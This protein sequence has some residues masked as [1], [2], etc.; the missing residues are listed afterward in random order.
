MGN[1]STSNFEQVTIGPEVV[2]IPANF[3]TESQITEITIP[4]TVTYIG[5]GSFSGCTSLE[6]LTIPSS[7]TTIKYAAFQGC[8]ITSLV[9]PDTVKILEAYCFK[10][11]KKLT[12]L[13]LANIDE[14]DSG[15]FEDCDS[16]VTVTIPA[17]MTHLSESM[18]FG[19]EALETL[20]ISSFCTDQVTDM[21]Y[22][23]YDCKALKE[24]DLMT[25]D[26]SKV[27]ISSNMFK[28]CSSLTTIYCND[29]WSTSSVLATSSDMFDGCTALQGGNGT[30]YDSSNPKDKTYARPDG[31]GGNK[32][33]FTHKDV[34]TELYAALGTDGTTMTMYY[35]S[36]KELRNG[37][38]S[39]EWSAWKDVVTKVVLHESVKDAKPTS[40]HTRFIEFK[41]LETIEHLEYLNT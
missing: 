34:P 29:D 7:V 41:A 36:K 27:T 33:Y 23:F 12:S 26:I 17:G 39:D 31:V 22:M 37:K 19:C 32:G 35:D 9:I 8:G 13:T 10:S 20:N 24:L 30:K 1:L 16:L 3:A 40:T 6:S 4:D 11:L 28:N 15:V 5:M 14:I 2:V 25:F 18:F 21:M 38:L